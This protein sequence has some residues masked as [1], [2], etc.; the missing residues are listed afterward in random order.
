MRKRFNNALAAMALIAVLPQPSRAQDCPL[1]PSASFAIGYEAALIPV[2]IDGTG[3]S[4]LV[5]TGGYIST[6]S[7]GVVDTLHLTPAQVEKGDELYMSD[8]TVLDQYVTVGELQL[9]VNTASAVR[10]I[11][12][13]QKSRAGLE[14]FA[15]TLAPDFLHDFDLDF[16]FGHRKLN[17]FPPDRCPGKVAYWTDNAIAVPFRTDRA[18]HIIVPA[19][20]DG[21]QT[22][23]IIDT[24]ASR[25]VISEEMARSAFHLAPGAGLEE[26]LGATD[27]SL[28][29]YEH[30]FK[31]LELNGVEFDDLTIGIMPDDMAK[32]VLAHFEFKMADRRPTGPAMNAYPI[33][34]GIDMLRKIH[35]YIDYKNE[36]LYITDASGAATTP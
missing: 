23:A 1:A 14:H 26:R 7:P 11:V 5:D 20:L 10:F 22:T 13:P 31:V 30:K 19:K 28:V 29:R 24:G 32:S 6:L 36:M 12:Q 9:G 15:G 27:R 17:L 33:I 21:V 8:G 2:I 25:T 35:L 4:F 34:I 18:H 16:D 3:Y